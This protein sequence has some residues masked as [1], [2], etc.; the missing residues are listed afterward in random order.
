M[1]GD[2]TDARTREARALKPGSPS[3]HDPYSLFKYDKVHYI[4]S[5]NDTLNWIQCNK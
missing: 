4:T 3:L 5:Q 2:T 1:E